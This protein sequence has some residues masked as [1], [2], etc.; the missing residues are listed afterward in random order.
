MDNW[1]WQWHEMAR[2]RV[3]TPRQT[4]LG[5]RVENLCPSTK[6]EVLEQDASCYFG[7]VEPANSSFSLLCQC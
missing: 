2:K 5:E 7:Q 4:S 6:G 1:Q 3:A